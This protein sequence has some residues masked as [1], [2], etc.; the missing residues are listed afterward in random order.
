MSED[1]D[2]PGASVTFRGGKEKCIECTLGL[3]CTEELDC[4][5][6][7]K[8]RLGPVVVGYLDCTVH[9]GKVC[10]DLFIDSSHEAP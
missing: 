6:S 3:S 10:K 1:R 9:T 5:S 4:R 2:L 8:E 7:S